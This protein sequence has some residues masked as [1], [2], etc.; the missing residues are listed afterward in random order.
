MSCLLFALLQE[1]SKSD[2]RLII[3]GGLVNLIRADIL[4]WSIKSA[5]M[6]GRDISRSCGYWYKVGHWTSYQLIP[7]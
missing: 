3:S 1:N 7:V 4:K 2:I 5:S 6:S